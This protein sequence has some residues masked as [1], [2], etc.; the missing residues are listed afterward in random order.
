MVSIRAPNLLMHA[1]QST[2]NHTEEPE[3]ECLVMIIEKRK[4]NPPRIQ[5]MFC[6]IVY[7]LKFLI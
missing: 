7:S 3:Q 5:I 4:E 6:D 2:P 1:Y